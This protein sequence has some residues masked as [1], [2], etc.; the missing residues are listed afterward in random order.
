MSEERLHV[1]SCPFGCRGGLSFGRKEPPYET[2]PMVYKIFM[3]LQQQ[4]QCFRLE[5][6]LVVQDDL[7]VCKKA[8][9]EQ[10]GG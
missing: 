2:S 9:V 1:F 8:C 3:L 10:A 6:Q 5:V 7:S 4:F